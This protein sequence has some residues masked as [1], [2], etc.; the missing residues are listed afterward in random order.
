MLREVSQD[1]N[2]KNKTIQIKYHILK[3]IREIDV[4][5]IES[6]ES[7]DSVRFKIFY[8]VFGIG[9]IKCSNFNSTITN[10]YNEYK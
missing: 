8:G 2:L 5:L 6:F 4:I 1:L 7:F 10:V 9:Q 3:D